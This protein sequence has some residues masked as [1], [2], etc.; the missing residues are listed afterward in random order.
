MLWMEIYWTGGPVECSMIRSLV[1]AAI[2]SC[3]E[4]LAYHPSALKCK[5]GAL[6]NLKHRPQ[7]DMPPAHVALVTLNKRKEMK[8]S[9]TSQDLPPVELSEMF[10]PWMDGFG[11]S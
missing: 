10:H 9:C 11:E 8:V 4:P 7:R 2:D 1:I 5:F 3:A 6:C